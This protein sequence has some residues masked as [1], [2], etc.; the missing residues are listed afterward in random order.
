[1]DALC[2]RSPNSHALLDVLGHEVVEAVVAAK[3]KEPPRDEALV[4]AK[5]AELVLP[6]SGEAVGPSHVWLD[7][8][9]G[10]PVLEG[11]P[12]VGLAR[13]LRVEGDDMGVVDDGELHAERAVRCKIIVDRSLEWRKGWLGYNIRL[14]WR[15]VRSEHVP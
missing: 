11:R 3:R 12:E 15:L 7:Q 8:Q 5:R 1:M 13:R 14:G 2:H 9:P 4:R 6:S 10:G